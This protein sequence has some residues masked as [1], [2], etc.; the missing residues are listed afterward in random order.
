MPSNPHCIINEAIHYAEKLRDTPTQN[1]SLYIAYEAYQKITLALIDVH[2]E[3]LPSGMQEYHKNCPT[4]VGIAPETTEAD[5][6]RSNTKLWDA[7][8]K[9]PLQVPQLSYELIKSLEELKN[10]PS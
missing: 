6:G 5:A 1:R 2:E 8:R 7:I 10:T 3:S 4:W 9:Y